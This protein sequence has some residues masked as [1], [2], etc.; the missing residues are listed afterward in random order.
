MKKLSAIALAC[1]MCLLALTGCSGAPASATATPA[2]SPESTNT[3]IVGFDAEYPP[4]SLYGGR[5][6]LY[7]F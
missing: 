6:K 7:G 1:L 2:P 4:F 3:F 5:R